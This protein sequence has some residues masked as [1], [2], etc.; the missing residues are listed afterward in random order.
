MQKYTCR[1]KE[2]QKDENVKEQPINQKPLRN[3]RIGLIRGPFMRVRGR[4]DI[5]NKEEYNKDNS[6]HKDY[7]MDIELN[8]D[9]SQ[10]NVIG[11]ELFI[12]F[13]NR[14]NSW[15]RDWLIDGVILQKIN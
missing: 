1:K 6:L 10:D 12:K 5:P 8:N 11:H 9:Y 3:V 4:V 15:K 14:N 2:D 13:E 7:I